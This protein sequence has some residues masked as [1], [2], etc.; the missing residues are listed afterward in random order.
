MLV[1]GEVL[2]WKPQGQ[3]GKFCEGNTEAWV[4]LIK[5]ESVGLWWGPGI[6]EDLFR[7]F[8]C[9]AILQTSI[10][11]HETFAVSWIFFSAPVLF[12]VNLYERSS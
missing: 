9:T 3:W 11:S 6:C 12:L 2:N 10:G 7:K 1:N 5:M 8:K 4:P